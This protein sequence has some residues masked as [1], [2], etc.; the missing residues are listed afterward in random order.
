MYYADLPKINPN[1]IV[2]EGPEIDFELPHNRD[3]RFSL[4]QPF[5][6]RLLLLSK[7]DGVLANLPQMTSRSSYSRYSYQLLSIY[8]LSQ[9]V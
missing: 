5:S 4:Q 7:R 6:V 8:S 3:R 1:R 9:A 2:Q